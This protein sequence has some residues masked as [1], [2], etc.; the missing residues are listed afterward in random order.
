MIGSIPELPVLIGIL[1][2][3]LVAGTVKGS[4]GIGFPAVVMSILP[5]IVSPTVGVA[6][7]SIP[8]FV[9]NAIQF[10]SVN[11]WPEIVRRFLLAGIVTAV[12]SFLVVRLVGDV[13]ARWI[14]IAV[15]LS[16]VLFSLAA[17]LKIELKPNEGAPWQVAVGVTSGLLG[18]V[19]AVQAPIM[20]YT[21]GLKLPREAFICAAGFLFF[22]GGVGLVAGAASSS[23]LNVPTTL[24][25]V[26]ACAAAL[27]G[28]RIGAWI[29][30]R[31]SD[32]WFRLILLWSILALGVRLIVTNL[33]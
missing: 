26:A 4:L 23:L 31:L 21:V 30:Q 17:L 33:F 7:L 2:I 24:M 3:F 15:G 6:L 19:S 1:V 32:K 14:N 10:L 11:G 9:T 20:V 28:F 5:I 27:A 16:L 12:A 29:R 13:P 22:T 8:I 18:G 25:S